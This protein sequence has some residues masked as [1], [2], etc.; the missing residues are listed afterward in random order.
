MKKLKEFLFVSWP[1]IGLLG[2][3]ILGWIYIKPM[4]PDDFLSLDRVA[5]IFKKEEGP[6]DPDA[7][8]DFHYVHD[9]LKPRIKP[10]L[11]ALFNTAKPGE[12]TQA[13]GVSH[14]V[15]NTDEL[16]SAI[17]NANSGDTIE[18][19][20]GIYRANLF[21]D[22][23]LNIIGQGTSTVIM[24]GNKGTAVFIENSKV[25]LYYLSI[26]NSNTA[27]KANNSQ[28]EIRGLIIENNKKSGIELRNSEFTI[29]DNI[30]TQNGSYG[31]F[32][33][34]DSKVEIEGNFIDENRGFEVRIEGRK[35]IYR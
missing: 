7:K 29:K 25:N 15:N 18:L 27:L 23:D 12:K 31:I 35:L 2:F 28:G 16:Q 13:D 34:A 21:I 30:I 1:F 3:I 19:D 11:V 33:D 6:V 4:L 5:N 8:Y 20:A 10:E 9:D 24:D 26:K 17:K 32:A 22:K 14:A